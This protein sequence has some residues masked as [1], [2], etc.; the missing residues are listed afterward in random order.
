MVMRFLQRPVSVFRKLWSNLRTQFGS[1]ATYGMAFVG[2]CAVGIVW[3]DV[4]TRLADEKAHTERA[5]VQDASNLTR[6]FAEHI[7]SV[8]KAVDQTLLYIRTSYQNDPEHF[9]VRQWSQANPLLADLLLRVSIIDKNGNLRLTSVPTNAGPTNMWDRDYFQF[10]L[11]SQKDELLIGQPVIG[12]ETGKWVLPVTRRIDAPDGSFAGV[13][14]ASI[15]PTYLSRFYESIDMGNLGVVLLVGTD[16]VIRARA[17]P[18]HDRSIGR[19]L[20]GSALMEHFADAPV[21]TYRSAALVDG[22]VRIYTYRAVKDLPLIVEVGFADNEIFAMY[23]HERE[24]SIMTATLLSVLLLCATVLIVRRQVR[25]QHMREALTASEHKYRS[26]VDNLNEVVF[27]TDSE[28]RWTF[29]NPAWA[30]LMGF[31]VAESLG[32]TFFNYVDPGDRPLHTKHFQPLLEG[33]AEGDRRDLRFV[34]KDHTLRWFEVDARSTRDECGKVVGLSGTLNDITQRKEVELELNQNRENLARAQRVAEIGSFDHD[35]VTDK[36]EWS[37]QLYRLYGLAPQVTVGIDTVAPLVHPDDR[38]AFLSVRTQLLQ[39]IRTASTDFRITRPDGVERVLSRQCDVTFDEAGKP[40]RLF[41]TVQD[42]TERKRTEEALREARDNADR[43]SR[44]KSEF[45]AM[46]SHEIRSPMSGVIGVIDLLR[47][48]P[49]DAEQKQM[50]EMVHESG[51]SLLGILNDILDFSKIEAGRITIAPEP[52]QLSRFIPSVCESSAHAASQKGLAFETEI[53]DGGPDWIKIDPVRL[54]QILVNLLSNAIKFT[55]QGSVRLVVAP[56]SDEAGKAMLTFTVT[57][58]GI[59]MSAEVISRLF[60]PFTQ[61][62]AS[63]TRDFG[64]TGLGLSI[65]LRLAQLLGGRIEVTSQPGIGSDFT[66][67]L[68]V[69]V[70][71]QPAAPA[72][73]EPLLQDAPRFGNRRVL[74]AEDLPTNRWLIARQLQHLGLTVDAVENGQAAMAALAIR[75][76]DLLISDFHMPKMDGIALTT[77]IR[78]AEARNG[79]ARLPI[80]GLTADA[81][82]ES[83]ERCL[84]AGMDWVVSKPTDLHSLSDALRRLLL[85]QKDAPP[86]PPANSR[87]AAIFD[88]HIYRELFAAHDPEGKEWLAGFIEAAR[89]LFPEIHA[90]ADAMDR[91]GL[92]ATA[93]RLAGIALSA[94]ALRLGESCRIIEAAAPHAEREDLLAAIATAEAAFR[95][96]NEEITRRFFTQEEVVS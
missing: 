23:S 79:S 82:G 37:D 41:G 57:D 39:G 18:K 70:P 71:D 78:E 12:R 48:T 59:G 94:G 85:A 73:Q 10:H 35:L 81:T 64:G 80:L 62:D 29:L 43:S 53:R 44:A 86:A 95:A 24:T 83:R 75:S 46:M 87:A 16:G 93:H 92:A 3:V 8:I 51:S 9:D 20:V 61:A 65:S 66:L 33:T 25:L 5:A 7:A 67:S 34:G 22:V 30:E 31:S 91:A 84:A 77:Q 69:V 17:S 26:V 36:V 14:V 1:F 54:R 13:V 50:V 56:A 27:Q 88:D 15:D 4:L 11:H 52:V 76:Y 68:P 72:P 60:T 32:N 40:R 28:G 19:S 47:Q 58:T 89:A 42:I 74:V 90:R 63:T 38:E 45:L 21:G 49:L 55:Q 6:T 96:A 2:L